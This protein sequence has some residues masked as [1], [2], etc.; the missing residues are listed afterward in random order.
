MN[1]TARNKIDVILDITYTA[2]IV[3]SL[4]IVIGAFLGCI[5]GLMSLSPFAVL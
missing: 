5:P 2:V 3:G 4:G 1:S